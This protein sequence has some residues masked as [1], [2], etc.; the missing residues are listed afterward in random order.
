MPTQIEEIL[1]KATDAG[2]ADIFLIA[3]LPPLFL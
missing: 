1:Q 2:A 3:G